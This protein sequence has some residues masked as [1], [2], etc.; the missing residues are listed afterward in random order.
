MHAFHQ[1][2]TNLSACLYRLQAVCTSVS[3]HYMIR[4]PQT[5]RNRS[6]SFTLL[7]SIP[8]YPP[9]PSFFYFSLLRLQI[10][11]MSECVRLGK[12]NNP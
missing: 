12:K 1:L 5:S 10:R 6:A 7:S 3:A 9:P 4:I 2:R 8:L 11:S